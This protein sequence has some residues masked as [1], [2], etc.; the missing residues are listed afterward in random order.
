M[1]IDEG[2]HADVGLD[3]AR[4]SRLETRTGRRAA[5]TYSLE[6][7]HLAVTEEVLIMIPSR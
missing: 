1:P 2:I 3:G 4:P 7:I 6:D 5:L